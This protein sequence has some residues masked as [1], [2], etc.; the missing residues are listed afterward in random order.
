MEVEGNRPSHLVPNWPFR[1][2]QSDTSVERMTTTFPT[3]ERVDMQADARALY[4]AQSALDRA[5]AESV[6]TPSSTSS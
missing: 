3:H 1:L 2:G 6:S 4:R 5:V